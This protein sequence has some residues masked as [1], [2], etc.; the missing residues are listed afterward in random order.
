MIP[1]QTY[2]QNN[3]NAT[4][5]CISC[6]LFAYFIIIIITYFHGNSKKKTT[7]MAATKSNSDSCLPALKTE[8]I[9]SSNY[10]LL[11]HCYAR[12]SLFW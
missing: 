8:E 11:W 5:A 3:S 10:L 9:A 4:D 2:R 6:I 1:C 12:Y 7:A